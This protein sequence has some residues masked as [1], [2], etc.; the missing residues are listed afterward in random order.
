M[1]H[2]PGRHLMIP[3]V[4]HFWPDA[5]PSAFTNFVHEWLEAH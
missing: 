3:G 4:N 2:L 5:E 1:R